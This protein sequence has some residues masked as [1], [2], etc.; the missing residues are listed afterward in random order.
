M[1]LWGKNMERFVEASGFSCGT[2]VREV[3]CGF[4]GGL[5]KHPHP[6]ISI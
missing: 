3:P 1:R 2:C 5:L 6:E 4:F